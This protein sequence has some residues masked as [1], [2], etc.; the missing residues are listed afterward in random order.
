MSVA[1][2]VLNIR[3]RKGLVRLGPLNKSPLI[4]ALRGRLGYVG[5]GS[6]SS[7]CHRIAGYPDSTAD[8]SLRTSV[9][10]IERT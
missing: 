5:L 10:A 3:Y 8:R 2:P 7:W 9:D 6:G 1:D 4:G